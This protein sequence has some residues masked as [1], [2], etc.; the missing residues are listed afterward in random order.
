MQMSS[1]PDIRQVRRR[2]RRPKAVRLGLGLSL[3]KREGFNL[4]GISDV[5]KFYALDPL[6]GYQPSGTSGPAKHGPS[7][8]ERSLEKGSLMGCEEGSPNFN[9][10]G[11]PAVGGMVGDGAVWRYGGG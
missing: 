7:L 5:G 10:P 4:L 6:L 3:R 11:D 9:Y 2:R 1:R 8:V